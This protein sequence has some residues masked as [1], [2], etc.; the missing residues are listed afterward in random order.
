MRFWD[1][2]ALAN[3]EG[4]LEVIKQALVKDNSAPSL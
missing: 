4:V 2:E 3:V 1:N